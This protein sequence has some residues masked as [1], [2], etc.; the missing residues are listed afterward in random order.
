[1]GFGIAIG[2]TEH[3]QIVTIALLLKIVLHFLSLNLLC[4]SVHILNT[5]RLSRSLSQEKERESW[6]VK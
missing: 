1:V 4:F 5:W 2:L 6:E 3:L